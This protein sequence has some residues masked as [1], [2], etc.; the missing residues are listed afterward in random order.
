M[1]KLITATGK[2]FACD[3]FNQFEPTRQL[4]IQIYNIPF[5]QAAAI[6]S[7][8]KETVQLWFENQYASNY[9]TL[10]SMSPVGD[11]IRVMLTRG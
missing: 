2:E 10:L 9:T 5:A 3:Y 4:S 11:S 1:E 7:D 8:P 6:F